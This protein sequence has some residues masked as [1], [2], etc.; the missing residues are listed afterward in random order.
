VKNIYIWE[1][2]ESQPDRIRELATYR[3]DL[4]ENSTTKTQIYFNCFTTKDSLRV[5][6]IY[7]GRHA[8]ESQDSCLQHEVEK[9]S[10]LQ[11]LIIHCHVN[12]LKVTSNHN[13]QK[14]R[15]VP[16]RKKGS[17]FLN[18]FRSHIGP[19]PTV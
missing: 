10:E 9:P 19:R 14:V 8:G 2:L 6:A 4:L 13:R 12:P 11:K 1:I 16:Q 7:S 3:Q 17:Y 5:G 18:P 15:L